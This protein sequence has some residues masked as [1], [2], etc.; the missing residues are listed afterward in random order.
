MLSDEIVQ[1]TALPPT[2]SKMKTPTLKYEANEVSFHNAEL[3]NCMILKLL[4]PF[5]ITGQIN[6]QNIGMSGIEF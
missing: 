2:K 3:S 6:K 4:H 5:Y 1:Y